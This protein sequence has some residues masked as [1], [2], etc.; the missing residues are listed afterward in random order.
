[1]AHTV[2]ESNLASI[3]SL[4][5]APYLDIVVLCLSFPSPRNFFTL[6]GCHPTSIVSLVPVPGT[7]IDGAGKPRQVAKALSVYSCWVE[8]AL[9]VRR[10]RQGMW[11][12][13]RPCANNTSTLRP[14]RLKAVSNTN[15]YWWAESEISPNHDFVMATSITGSTTRTL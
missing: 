3:V 2:A 12:G 4:R 10:R 1:M 13:A 9:H 6:H 7:R 14:T 5:N 15:M 11:C 8:S